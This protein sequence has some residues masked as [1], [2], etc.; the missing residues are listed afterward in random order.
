MQT[1]VPLPQVELNMESVVVLRWLVGVGAFVEA[2]KPIMEVET[3]K[4]TVEVPAP[5]SGFV[6][7]LLVKEGDTIGDKAL[8]CVMTSTADEAVV[9]VVTDAPKSE[10][11]ST[12]ESIA[13]TSN[14]SE[15]GIVRAVPAARKLASDL[16]IDLKSVRG[17]GPQGRITVED[18]RGAKQVPAASSAQAS[19]DWSPI[20]PTRVALVEQM[21]KGLAEIP[22]IQLFREIDVTTLA[23]KAEGITFTHR[24][25]IA[26]AAAL[27]AH[28]S[29]RT[30]IDGLRIRTEPVSVAVAIDTGGGLVAPAIRDANRLSLAQVAQKLKDLQARAT[31]KSLR[32][33]ELTSAPFAI[34]NL[35]MLGVDFFSPFV[36]HGQTAVMSV[37][38]ARDGAGG[39]KVAWFGLAVDHR[40]VDGAEAAKFL[41]TLQA[42]IVKA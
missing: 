24:L 20:P 18:V 8:L 2:D 7:K 35:G 40:V 38:R 37:G 25:V 30:M 22:Q 17:T 13:A 5:T 39:R 4:A 36:F 34:T 21:R 41:Q 42:E 14:E 29:L 16:G 12:T 23:V 10:A 9:D 3:Q 19:S 1:N 11:R 6:R 15:S 33:E 28:P 27:A 31:A 32:K 26:T